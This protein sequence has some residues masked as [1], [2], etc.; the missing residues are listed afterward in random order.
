MYNFYCCCGG[1]SSLF[2]FLGQF[3]CAAASGI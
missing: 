3:I 2:I 1:G